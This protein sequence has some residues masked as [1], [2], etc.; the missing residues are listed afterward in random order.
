MSPSNHMKTFVYIHIK[1]H[2]FL[3][4]KY[5]TFADNISNLFI[6]SNKDHNMDQNTSTTYVLPYSK[7]SISYIAFIINHADYVFN[8]HMIH[9]QFLDSKMRSRS[10]Q[11]LAFTQGL[12]AYKHNQPKYENIS[13]NTKNGKEYEIWTSIELNVQNSKSR[14]TL[15]MVMSQ[16]DE[17]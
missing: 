3:F 2:G 17:D 1:A 14:P 13:K 4:T 8:I 6:K 15:S 11:G 9:S 10:F 12:S 5:I 16:L 7:P